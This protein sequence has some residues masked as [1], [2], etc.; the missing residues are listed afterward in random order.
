MNADAPG[1]A[2]PRR[3]AASRHRASAPAEALA[4]LEWVTQRVSRAL[5]RAVDL[6]AADHGITAAEYHL[7]LAISDDVG[8]SNAEIARLTFVTPQS[9]NHVLAEL[10]R[11]AFLQRT[12]DPNH[13]RIRHAVLTRTGREVLDSCTRQIA[14]IEARVVAGLDEQQRAVL[15]PALW[16]AAETL[17]GGFFGDAAEEARAEELRRARHA[18]R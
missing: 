13:G 17:A 3:S 2:R 12:D 11:R 15:L 6:V 5:Q 1:T 8:R 7:L 9:A 4:R 16:Q 18:P 14:A 10:E